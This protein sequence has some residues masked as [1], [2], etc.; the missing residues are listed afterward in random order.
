MRVTLEQAGAIVVIALFAVFVLWGRTASGQQAVK[1]IF[2]SRRD[3]NPRP[4]SSVRTTRTAKSK[5][6]SGS[7]SASK[8]KSGRRR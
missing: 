3:P 4:T 2:G 8:S 6:S 1:R 5:R 7:R